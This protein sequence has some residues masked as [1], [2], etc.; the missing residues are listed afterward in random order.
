MSHS[1]SRLDFKQIIDSLEKSSSDAFLNK[2]IIKVWK[3][4][5][6]KE[7]LALL[8]F[9]CHM[10]LLPSIQYILNQNPKLINIQTNT[11]AYFKNIE[12]NISFDCK[13]LTPL[14]S[15][16]VN[17]KKSKF[18]VIDWLL[19]QPELK[20]FEKGTGNWS[21]YDVFVITSLDAFSEQKNNL[22]L[23]KKLLDAGLELIPEKGPANQLLF[24]LMEEDNIRFF[25]VALSQPLN[26]SKATSSFKK[27]FADL[28]EL[29]FDLFD[30]IEYRLFNKEQKEIIQLLIHQ[31]LPNDFKIKKS[32]QEWCPDEVVLFEREKLNQAV[33]SSRQFKK[34]N[35][36]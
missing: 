11:F 25:K 33:P 23:F 34:K 20:L 4:V 29:R 6:P 16:M 31:D 36:L 12:A 17:P 5:T 8:G 24:E 35:R 27:K 28:L 10:G 18:K 30:D 32:F 2:E 9:A 22:E 7:Q 21:I 3:D 15:A 1:N 19:K 26:W 14:L 13:P